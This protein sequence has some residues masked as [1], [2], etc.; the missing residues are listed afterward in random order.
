MITLPG[1][2]RRMWKILLNL[3]LSLITVN[4]ILIWVAKLASTF[5]SEAAMTFVNVNAPHDGEAQLAQCDDALP[6][7]TFFL[8]CKQLFDMLA[9]VAILCLLLPISAVLIC[10]NPILNP[11]PLFYVQSRMGRNCI[12]FPAIKFRTMR[13]DDAGPR[14][15]DDPV[16]IE[17][18]TALGRF[19]RQT[20]IDELSQAI[21]VLRGEMSVIG[22][23]PDCYQHALQF[24][25]QIPNYERR[26]MVSPGISGLAQTELGY[27]VGVA[28]TRK[29]VRADLRYI[30]RRGFR[31]EAW[32]IW[33][34]FAVILGRPGK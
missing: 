16:E 19:L 18:T 14:S 34:T 32:I 7:G 6:N 8:V 15:L 22:P 17:R 25:A 11:G 1:F 12:A 13:S 4:Q 23:R 20:H 5:S 33:R 9:S 21:N 27:A 29:K 30:K 31:M 26:H 28:A 2:L 3:N 10:L 24:M